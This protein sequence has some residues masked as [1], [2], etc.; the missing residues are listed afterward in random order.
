MYIIKNRV[1]N[2]Y[3]TKG[4]YRGFHI[5]NRCA[6]DK[7][8]HAKNHVTYKLGSFSRPDGDMF[9]WY[10]NADFIEVSEHGGT[11][12]KIPVSDYLREYY[13]NSYKIRLLNEEQK[14]RL[15]LDGDNNED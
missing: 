13:K 4:I 6:W 8:S 2:E 11:L 10:M 12:A 15:G 14:K 7:L 5:M 3:D 1:S 9:D